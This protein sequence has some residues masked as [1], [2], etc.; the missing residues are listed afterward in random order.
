MYINTKNKQTNIHSQTSIYLVKPMVM[1]GFLALT[2]LLL[3]LRITIITSHTSIHS[4]STSS[5]CI[6]TLH[7]ALLFMGLF[8]VKTFVN[9][10]SRFVD[11]GQWKYGN[12]NGREGEAF[13]TVIHT[14][15]WTYKDLIR[16]TSITSLFCFWIFFDDGD[17]GVSD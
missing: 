16:S 11:I 14:T 5:Y 2:E 15:W 7:V 9:N 17:D 12:T 4:N 10:S 13:S 6:S 3:H 1:S 8:T